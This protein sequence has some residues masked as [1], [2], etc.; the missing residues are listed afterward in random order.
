MLGETSEAR[1]C[2]E[3][4][5]TFTPN[6]IGLH[7]ALLSCLEADGDIEAAQRKFIAIEDMKRGQ[8]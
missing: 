3:D 2:L 1:S 8:T 6:E 7:E 5:C 4:A